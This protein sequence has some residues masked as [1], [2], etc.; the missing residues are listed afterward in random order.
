MPRRRADKIDNN[1]RAIVETLRA[2]PGISVET[3]KD[4]ILIGY[5]GSTY[6]YEVKSP[7]TVSKKTG[8][9][10]ESAKKTGQKRLEHEF[11]GHYRIVFHVEQILEDIGI[12]RGN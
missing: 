3:G 7:D 8:E 9:I 5:R 10:R 4:D 11:N 2:I 6:W 12:K 1:Q